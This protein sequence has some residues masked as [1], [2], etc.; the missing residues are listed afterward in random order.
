MDSNQQEAVKLLYSDDISNGEI[1]TVTEC[2]IELHIRIIK[3]YQKLL[4]LEIAFSFLEKERNIFLSQKNIE[5][6]REI[7]ILSKKVLELENNYF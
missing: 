7:S 1:T 4:E 6:E 3:K 2:K 5:L